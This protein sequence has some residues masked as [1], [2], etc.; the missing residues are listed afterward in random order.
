MIFVKMVVKVLCSYLS[1]ALSSAEPNFGERSRIKCHKKSIM[2]L[3]LLRM[4]SNYHMTQSDHVISFRIAYISNP[5]F[6]E[7]H[8]V[9]SILNTFNSW[10]NSQKLLPHTSHLMKPNH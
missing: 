4:C 5:V 8:L 1:V 2:S 6:L 3:V 9:N 7:I 10:H